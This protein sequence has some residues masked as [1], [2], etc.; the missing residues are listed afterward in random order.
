MGSD[1]INSSCGFNCN[2]VDLTIGLAN[3]GQSFTASCYLTAGTIAITE[4][5]PSRMKRT[6]SG[7]GTCLAQ[8]GSSG[9]FTV[10]NG[11][12]DVAIV[13]DVP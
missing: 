1:T 5:S 3:S 2:G 9:A 13:P 8:G 11:M 4:K 10:M 6:F 7:T 12:F